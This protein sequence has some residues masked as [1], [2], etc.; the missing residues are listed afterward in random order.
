MCDCRG[1]HISY[2]TVAVNAMQQQHAAAMLQALRIHTWACGLFDIDGASAF[3]Q[4][5]H[6]WHVSDADMPC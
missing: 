4:H 1:S 6:H 2:L 3:V 5:K